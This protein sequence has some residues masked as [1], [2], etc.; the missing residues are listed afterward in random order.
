LNKVIEKAKSPLRGYRNFSNIMPER[1][2]FTPKKEFYQ[3][4]VEESTPKRSYSDYR[5][6]NYSSFI[7]KDEDDFYLPNTGIDQAFLSER[8]IHTRT[9]NL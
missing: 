9:T 8:P 5:K 7:G 3:E 6:G 2:E 1:K 4:Y